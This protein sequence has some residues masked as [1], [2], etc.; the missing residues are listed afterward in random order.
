MSMWQSKDC[1]NSLR[2]FADIKNPNIKM[3]H[4]SDKDLEYT[5]LVD[6]NTMESCIIKYS[7]RIAY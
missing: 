7:E 6:L 4:H 5:L 2:K 3:I 1:S